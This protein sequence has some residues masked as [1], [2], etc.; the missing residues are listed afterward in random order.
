MF[1]R[2]KP[3]TPPS[4]KLLPGNWRKIPALEKD[5]YL[6][7]IHDYEPVQKE[8]EHLRILLHGPINAGKSSFINSV[9]T[10]LRNRMTG[11]ALAGVG[12][13]SFTTMYKTHKIQKRKPGNFYPFVF[14]DIMGLEK[15]QGICVDDIKLAMKGHM[16][17]GYVFNPHSAFTSTDPH[18]NPTPTLSDRAHVLV[19][20]VSASTLTLMSETET[21]SKMKQV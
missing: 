1:R 13:D 10:A 6:Q 15:D 16:K 21:M 9:E 12:H 8:V 7:Y 14:N 20:V 2:A 3:P 18:Y 5:D 19:C 4:P 17:D 11:Q